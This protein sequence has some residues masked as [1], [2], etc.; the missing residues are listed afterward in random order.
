MINKTSQ[1]V[2]L[3]FL[4]RKKKCF[5]S[6]KDWKFEKLKKE[7]CWK[8]H[9]KK[10][11]K[12]EKK[13]MILFVTHTLNKKKSL[14]Q[15]VSFFLFS[16]YT[17]TVQLTAVVNYINLGAIQLLNSVFKLLDGLR[18]YD[19]SNLCSSDLQLFCKLQL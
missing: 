18:T 16:F 3:R 2:Q 9:P 5:T 14:H 7:Q 15:Q 4:G 13:Q 11:K 8:I 19:Y 17:K 1:Q 6:C 12:K 10:K